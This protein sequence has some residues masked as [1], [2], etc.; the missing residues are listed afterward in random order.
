MAN[1]NRVV[2]Y[3][4][5]K[6]DAEVMRKFFQENDW[7]REKK[8][9]RPDKMYLRKTKNGKYTLYAIPPGK[10]TKKTER[11]KRGKINGRSKKKK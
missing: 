10:S 6:R 5:S 3:S 1:K 2:V 8:G 4:G 9:S 7:I 11:K